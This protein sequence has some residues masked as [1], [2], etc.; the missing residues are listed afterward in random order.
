MTKQYTR[1]FLP[2][3]VAALPPTG[4]YHWV[5]GCDCSCPAAV[6]AYF[7]SLTRAVARPPWYASG[8]Y[9]ITKA[10]LCL[11]NAFRQVDVRCQA[12]FPGQVVTFWVDGKGDVHEPVPEDLW[13][14]AFLSSCLRALHGRYPDLP[15]V[16][17]LPPLPGQGESLF[18]Q[19]ATKYFWSGHLLG[20]ADE[21][22]RHAHAYNVLTVTLRDLYA[23]SQRWEALMEHFLPLVEREPALA[24][25]VAEAF[26]QL[27]APDR[28]LAL[29]SDALAAATETSTEAGHTA[30]EKG[31]L[32]V[33]DANKESKREFVLL[34][35]QADVLLHQGKMEDAV[36]A[37]EEAVVEAGGDQHA[38][39]LLADAYS[40]LGAVDMA[41]V[42]LNEASIRPL[43]P[44]T[45]IGVPRPYKQINGDLPFD[46]NSLLFADAPLLEEEEDDD[47]LAGVNHRKAEPLPAQLYRGIWEKAFSLLVDIVTAVGW[48]EALE[49]RARVFLMK[50][51][52]A[53]NPSSVSKDPSAKAAGGGATVAGA[54]FGAEVDSAGEA[55]EAERATS[56]VA[57]V[58]GGRRDVDADSAA[59]VM[60]SC[61]LQQDTG[62]SGGIQDKDATRAAEKELEREGGG[63]GKGRWGED[64]RGAL[65]AGQQEREGGVGAGGR[66]KRVC[67]PWLD[68]LFHALYQDL[69]AYYQWLSEEESRANVSRDDQSDDDEDEQ[70]ETSVDEWLHRAALARRLHNLSEAER[71]L[72]AAA[73]ATN[74]PRAWKALLEMYAQEACVKESLVAAH[75]LLECYEAFSV[76]PPPLAPL[77]IHKAVCRLV[78]AHG[79]QAVRKAQDAIGVAHP[80]VND[81]FH[82]IVRC[83]VH[84]FD[85]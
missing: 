58:D 7:D 61:P 54:K 43:K 68:A 37:A 62:A 46:A 13:E 10:T 59:G 4:Y 34:L 55:G 33:A 42:M 60:A 74:S 53:S 78:W 12:T 17:L 77:V 24:V 16:R 18:V 63:G 35:K 79:L 27:D 11:Y 14:E 30:T 80:V 66:R 3:D 39:L 51:D 67:R 29:L 64:G 9:A 81:L 84:G 15:S 23:N 26:V 22:P 38:W 40:R 28:A 32:H 20:N 2:S 83:R 45:I 49:V 21:E 31:E 52:V 72:R 85:R 75:E 71:A 48:D 65:D 47:L 41:L 36:A 1:A 73:A 57:V 76:S 5:L 56:E 50:E 69:K 6:C 82:L 70:D 44:D 19:L 25:H 8:G